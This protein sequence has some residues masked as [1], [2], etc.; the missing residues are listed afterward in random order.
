MR[1]QFKLRLIQNV[2]LCRYDHTRLQLHHLICHFPVEIIVFVRVFK[3]DTCAETG[4][5]EVHVDTA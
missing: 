1:H 2:S 4:K 5:L 3:Y